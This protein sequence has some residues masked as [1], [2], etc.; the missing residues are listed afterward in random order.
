MHP[1]VAGADAC[2]DLT[3][4]EACCSGFF[5]G[6]YNAFGDLSA[7]SPSGL[8]TRAR[9]VQIRGWIHEMRDLR[10]VAG[11]MVVAG[12]GFADLG[13]PFERCMKPR[14]NINRLH[15]QSGSNGVNINSLISCCFKLLKDLSAKFAPCHS[16]PI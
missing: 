3:D 11:E 9:D 15:S 4:G 13:K 1:A 7:P 8:N 6:F 16:A 14:V 2:G 10:E 12:A 5:Q